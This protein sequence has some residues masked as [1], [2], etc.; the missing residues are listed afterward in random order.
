LTVNKA[1]QTISFTESHRP[2]SSA[3]YGKNFTAVA[4]ATSGLAVNYSSSGA[5]SNSGGTYHMTSGTSN[6]TVIVN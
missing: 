5:A 3:V 4:T 2:P 6:A 1:A